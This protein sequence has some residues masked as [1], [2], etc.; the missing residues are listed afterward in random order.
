MITRSVKAFWQRHLRKV[1]L[2]IKSEELQEKVVG[3]SNQMLEELIV[4]QSQAH[5]AIFNSHEPKLAHKFLNSGFPKVSLIESNIKMASRQKVLTSEEPRINVFYASIQEDILSPAKS[6]PLSKQSLARMLLPAKHM[7][8]KLSLIIGCLP[9]LTQQ[10][11]ITTSLLNQLLIFSRRAA[12]EKS[13]TNRLLNE[14]SNNDHLLDFYPPDTIYD[15]TRPGLITFLNPGQLTLLKCNQDQDL[16]FYSFRNKLY[17]FL[18]D[19]FF[20]VIP[21]TERQ[22]FGSDCFY[23]EAI[24]N[25]SIT[26]EQKLK[27]IGYKITDFYPLFIMP[28]DIKA[29]LKELA[30]TFSDYNSS[31][32]AM[33]LACWMDLVSKLAP[34]KDLKAQLVKLFP[35]LEVP[36]ELEGPVQDHS[37]E[38]IYNNFPVGQKLFT[39][40]EGMEIFKEFVAKM[41][42]VRQGNYVD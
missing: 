39:S 18:Y 22:G 2:G 35:D 12:V 24:E 15:V 32:I 13:W 11:T 27:S 36:G 41:I 20:T 29:V 33:E 4:K 21:L 31:L 38:V 26:H 37:P 30:E 42:N 17:S 1:G 5:I 9:L 34:T 16:E 10:H 40:P 25:T 23:P 6:S 19:K 14:E 7:N 28:K 8:N 3:W